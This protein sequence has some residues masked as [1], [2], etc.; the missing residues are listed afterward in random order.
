MYQIPPTP[1]P[2]QRILLIPAMLDG[3]F[4]LLQYAFH[5]P[6]YYPV[7]LETRQGIEDLGLRR[8]HNDMCYP[9][10]LSLGQYLAALDSGAY[11]PDRVSLLMPSAGD[12]CRGSNFTSLIRKGLAA[13]GYPQVEVLTLNV[14]GLEKGQT[15][16]IRPDMVWR[17]LFGVFYGDLLMLLTHQ[18][19][20]YEKDPGATDACRAKWT[21]R[22]AQDLKTGRHLT[23]R[24]MKQTFTQ[25]A[26]DFA[27][28]PRR[29]VSRKQVA[30]VGE[31]YTKY[32]ALGNWDMVAF[33]EGEGCEVA[34]NGFSWYLLYFAGNQLPEHTGPA[35]GLWRLL[36]AW[37]ARLQQ[38]MVAALTAHGFH[39]L[40]PFPAF[41]REA[42]GW[43]SQTL[44]VADGWLMGAEIAAHIQGG[45]H[46]VLAMQ[47]FGCLPNHVCGRGQYAA[48]ARRLGR[49][50]VVSVDLDASSPRLLV[51]NRVKLLLEG[52]NP[53]LG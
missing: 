51:Y 31:L 17:A 15:L 35:W 7:V 13:A 45:C 18:T 4:P 6:D 16:P 27:A 52:E 30:L 12:A 19:R 36:M 28:I 24:A 26:A 38:A 41:Q 8:A 43:I 44:Q 46:R 1:G 49:G 2:R 21:D 29:A 5:S 39:S 22:L 37:M 34:V 20:P 23:I 9:F 53:P 25:A 50:K 11:D 14:R 33:L 42:Q 40:P 10:I 32:C 3:H 48:L 47:P